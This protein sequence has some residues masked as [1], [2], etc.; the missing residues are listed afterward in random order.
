MKNISKI[1]LTGIIILTLIFS[2][3]IMTECQ[4]AKRTSGSANK[5]NLRGN[6]I[7]GGFAAESQEYIFYS[8]RD[9]GLVSIKKDGSSRKVIS[10]YSASNMNVVGNYIY[11]S[12]FEGKNKSYLGF[13]KM[14]T[15]GTG[16]KKI[17]DSWLDYANVIDGWIYFLYDYKLYKMKIDGTS[18]KLLVDKDINNFC[19]ENDSIYYN[20]HFSRNLIKTDMNGTHE[21][22]L[23]TNVGGLTSADTYVYY[24]CT[25]IKDSESGENKSG[26]FKIGK[27]DKRTVVAYKNS[28][29][30]YMN[31]FNGWIYYPD[32]KNIMR[33][34]TDGTKTEKI[35][36]NEFNVFDL[37]VVGDWLFYSTY[38]YRN[39]I[40]FYKIKVDG[41]GKE[42]MNPEMQTANDREKLSK[43]FCL[44][45]EVQYPTGWE[46]VEVDRPFVRASFY[47]TKG[48]SEDVYISLI[49]PRANFS[50]K[51][52]IYD[53]QKSY[54][55]LA[56][57]EMNTVIDENK[58]EKNDQNIDIFTFSS[59]TVSEDKSA[60]DFETTVIFKSDTRIIGLYY[61]AL[62][63]GLR[64]RYD[65]TFKVIVKSLNL[66]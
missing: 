64:E 13:F 27:D 47:P 9:A 52:T 65:S 37:N 34:K 32:S 16:M 5:L 43:F 42:D 57:D 49:N 38:Y 22:K 33:V 14:K 53:I 36:T 40:K 66:I 12:L 19:I 58:I 1:F 7:N 63:N 25:L 11:C 30:S 39:K 6:I 20:E 3:N 51:E 24:Y 15:D 4:S 56:M 48:N 61:Y 31:A 62:T 59:H 8:N 46:L 2:S 18:K 50:D 35:C 21:K 28:S 29:A 55:D 41:S 44:G 60:K 10:K 45:A 17:T 26:I 54:T 23:A